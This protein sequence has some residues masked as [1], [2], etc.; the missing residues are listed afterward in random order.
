M[1]KEREREREEKKSADLKGQLEILIQ[2]TFC[3]KSANIS[4]KTG[5][6]IWKNGADRTAPHCVVGKH[7]DTLTDELATDARTQG[8]WPG[9][10]RVRLR[11]RAPTR[12]GQ[13]PSTAT[14]EKHL[15]APLTQFESNRQ[16]PGRRPRTR[17]EHE[18]TTDET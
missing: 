12:A 10:K 7:H 3:I 18:T 17:R 11:V 8:F 14:T 4:S 2:Y 9:G 6:I 15:T 13:S 5:K 16:K 1:Q